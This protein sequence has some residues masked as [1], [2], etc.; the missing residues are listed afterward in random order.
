MP[1]PYGAQDGDRKG[2]VVLAVLSRHDPFVLGMN[3]LVEA[4]SCPLD[5]AS[6]EPHIDLPFGLQATT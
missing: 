4:P 5:L 1:S 3:L 2:H 6:G